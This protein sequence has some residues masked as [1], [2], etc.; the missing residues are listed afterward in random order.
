MDAAHGWW[1]KGLLFENCNGE[2]I[3]R[4]HLSFHNDCDHDRCLFHWAL[5]IED[6]AS[7]GVSP[8]GFDAVPIADSPQRTFDGAVVRPE[9]PFDQI[10]SSPS[11]GVGTGITRFDDQGPSINPERT[12][13]LYS[14]FSWQG[15]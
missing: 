12:Y 3:C 15:P 5:R 6:G 1:A 14:D 9:N 2:L 8:A 7:D 11:Q 10:H 4:A 13:A